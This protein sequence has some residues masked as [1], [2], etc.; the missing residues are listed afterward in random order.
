MNMRLEADQLRLAI[1]SL[2]SAYPDLAEDEQLRADMLEGETDLAKVLSKI[3]NMAAE[4]ASMEMAIKMRIADLATR[5]DRY[6]Q[7]EEAFRS[8]IASIM[9]KASLSKFTLPEATLSVT[10]RK[11][12]PYIVE[13]TMLPE[14]CFQLVRK[15]DMATIKSWV[16]AGNMPSGVVMSNGKS[17][18][19]VRTR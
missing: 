8:L 9:D 6:T 3:V 7:R 1:D 16:A 15:P 14:E 11:P 13:E 4:A 19:T 10:Y 5:K 18:L 17:V 2:L 12:T